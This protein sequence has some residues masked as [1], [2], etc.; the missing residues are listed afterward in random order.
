MTTVPSPVFHDP[1]LPAASTAARWRW[2][3]IA[4]LFVVLAIAGVVQCIY[5]Q[6]EP[7]FDELWHL[8]LSTGRGTPVGFFSPDQLFEACE[9]LTSL[10]GAPPIWRIWTTLDGMPHPPLYFVLLRLWREVV[11]ESDRVGNALSIACS[12][13]GVAFTFAA[14]RLAMNCWA[15]ALAG[16]ALGCAQTQVYLAQEMR[17]YALATAIAAAALWLMTRIELLGPTRAA[18]IALAALTLPLMLTHYFTVGT[19]IAISVYGFARLRPFRMTFTLTLVTG[20]IVFAIAWLGFALRQAHDAGPA[21][22][23]LR[24]DRLDLLREVA[25]LA[26]APF[27]LIADREY[28]VER[29]ALLSGVLFV[30]PWM[31]ARRLRP[32]MP[33]GLAL[34]GGIVPV[35][36]VDVFGLR[37]HLNIIRYAAVASPAVMLLFV[38]CAWAIDRRLAYATG[39]TVLA[40]GLAYLVSRN[41]VVGECPDF[42]RSIAIVERSAAPDDAILCYAGTAPRFYADMMALTATHSHTLLPRPLMVFTKPIS[43]DVRARLPARAWIL[44]GHFDRP[45]EE[46]IPGARVV[47]TRVADLEVVVT[48]VELQDGATQ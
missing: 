23:Y 9:R 17:P 33:W 47:S 13:V 32:L 31:L 22:D 35:F 16:L 2:P 25:L 39:A 10:A 3:D 4:L 26:C 24:T 44:S 6:P 8:M 1:A 21:N 48:L 19:C 15:A 20:A 18:A 29:L 11:G 46:L 14:G 45:L 38:G 42:A 37:T 36:L 7:S 40:A 12:L 28:T 41:P 30:L 27:R 43:S 34:C 5:I